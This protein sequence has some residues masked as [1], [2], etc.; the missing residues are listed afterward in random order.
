MLLSAFLVCLD[1]PTRSSFWLHSL[2]I[3]IVLLAA[4]LRLFGNDWDQYQH[5]H[6]DE[7]YIAW[8]AST[9]EMPDRWQEAVDPHRSTANLFYWP[10]VETTQ[11]IRVPKDEPRD[12]AYGHLPIYV[13]V[14]IVRQLE[15]ITPFDNGMG[16]INQQLLNGA[17][18]IEFDH[19]TV[20]GRLLTALADVITV[21]LIFRLG[22]IVFDVKVG[23]LAAVFLSLTVIH[24]QSAHFFITDPWMTMFVVA[25]ILNMVKA[26][27]G[28]RWS[29]L[30]AAIFTGLAIGSKF[31]ATIVILPLIV[32]TLIIHNERYDRTSHMVMSTL[33]VSLLAAGT[34]VIT[35][36]FA[37][38]D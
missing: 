9:I 34:V 2:I 19:I 22:K 36:P 31:S 29:L 8:V 38:L 12:F 16:F 11:G 35:N 25:A 6:P 10:S 13:T 15:K 5:L 20:V 17:K 21:L 37:F 18:Q 24:I 23:L 28:G 3:P 27:N 1:M 33:L 30:F 7:R 26:I 4:A 32:T 14:F